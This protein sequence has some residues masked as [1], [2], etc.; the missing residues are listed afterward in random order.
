MNNKLYKL[1]NWP[2]IEEIIYS[3]G[4][5][6]HRILGAHKVGSNLLIQTF[7][8]MAEEIEVVPSTGTKKYKMEL[9]DEAGFY[10]ALVPYKEGFKYKYRIKLENGDIKEIYDAYNFDGRMDREDF[11]KFN[12][13]MHYNIYEKFGAHLMEIDGVKGCA[14]AVWAPDAARVSVIGDFNDWDGRVNQMR[15]VDHDGVFEIFI[16]GAAEGD[17]YQ[18]EVKTK[19]G[20]IFKRPDPYGYA[21]KDK[22]SQVSKITSLGDIKWNDSAFIK[23]RTKFN[24]DSDPLSICELSLESF[25]AKHKN[26]IPDYEELAKEILSYV[27]DHGFNTIELKPVMEHIQGH[28]FHIT[29]F[30]AIQNKYGDPVGF[31]KFVNIMHEA[32]IRVIMDFVTTFF[33]K[34][35]CGLN[36]FDGQALYEYPDPRMGVHPR[37]GDLIFDFGRKQV[38]NFLLSS[39]LFWVSTFHLDGLRV[40][41]IAK[42]LYLDYDRKPGQWIPNMYGGNEN[43]E[44]KDFLCN[45]NAVLKQA[46]PGLLTLTKETSCWPRVTGEL[47]DGGLGFDYKW[48][49]GWTKDFLDYIQNDP[50]FRSGNHNELTFSLVYCYTERFVLAFTHEEIGKG[51]E[52]LYDLMPGDTAQ[53][54]AGVRLAISYLMT[55]PG[56]KMIYMDPNELSIDNAVFLENMIHSL[57]EIYYS[58]PALYQIDTNDSGFEWINSMA[59][60][61]CMMSFMRKGESDKDM[62]I[63]VVNMAGVDRTFE[64]GVPADGKYYEIFNSDDTCYGGSG[65][66]NPGRIEADFSEADGRPYSIPVK[67]ASSS[68]AIFSYTPYTTQ[69]KKIRKIREEEANNKMQ[70]R[71]KTLR[72]LKNRQEKEEAELLKELH[73]RYEKELAAQEEAIEKKYEQIEEERISSIVSEAALKSISGGKKT[74]AKKTATPKTAAKGQKTAASKSAVK[75]APAKKTT[76]KTSGT[77]TSNTKTNKKDDNK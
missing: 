61:E 30:F 40:A 43:L 66:V 14:F 24:R 58:R 37:T 72:E 26:H 3:D 46:Y 69:E 20:V 41:D 75:K 45:F 53:K 4:D 22:E 23:N 17:G 71:E 56:K 28:P 6:P 10:A 63:I 47:D 34:L 51:L 35:Q 68:L 5:D 13:G 54:M 52:G 76:R 49:N 32:G 48:N 64:V 60:E 38:T 33:P 9:A 50:L 74:A 29:G 2:E 8:P 31:K 59:A 42:I 16:P 73:E 65:M 7:Y 77:K 62:L 12:S 27:Q 36:S 18:F 39:A 21:F 25:A 57:N 55:H 15:R 70:E 44:A 1:M 11:I 19:G 67:V